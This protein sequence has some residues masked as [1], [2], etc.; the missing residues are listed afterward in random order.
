[1]ARYWYADMLVERQ[2]AE[3]LEQARDLL[4][5]AALHSEKIG[6]ALYTR[7]ARETEP[8]ANCGAGLR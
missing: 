4:H 3:D 7:L 5:T 8:P 6:L 2:H 1:M